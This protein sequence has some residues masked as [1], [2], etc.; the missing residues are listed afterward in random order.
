MLTKTTPLS[1]A[2]CPLTPSLPASSPAHRFGRISVPHPDGSTAAISAPT[3]DLAPRQIQKSRGC[4]GAVCPRRGNTT[5][6]R[7]SGRQETGG[8]TGQLVSRRVGVLRRGSRPAG[9]PERPCRFSTRVCPGGRAQEAGRRPSPPYRRRRSLLGP[10]RERMGEVAEKTQGR[11]SPLVGSHSTG[12]AAVHLASRRATAFDRS[13]CTR[14][15]AEGIDPMDGPVGTDRDTVKHPAAVGS[16]THSTTACPSLHRHKEPAI[17]STY[18]SFE[19]G[20]EGRPG[21]ETVPD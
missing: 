11:C 5:A 17:P 15:P 10:G 20:A 4:Q 13:V 16:E 18:R 7:T 1:T 2:R 6:V 3:P 8:W 12:R 14:Q 21:L 19:E 9:R